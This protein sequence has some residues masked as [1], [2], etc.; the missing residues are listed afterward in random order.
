[1][2]SAYSGQRQGKG[3]AD[4]TS[5]YDPR[6]FAHLSEIEQRHFW[7]RSRNRFIEVLANQVA[8]D[9]PAGFRI[10]EV[11]CGVGSVL[12]V[13]QR[14]CGSGVVF[15]VDLYAEALT[16]ARR[17]DRRLAQADATALPF[18][19]AFAL[20]GLFDVLEHVS[21]DDAVLREVYRL[22]EPPGRL[23]L[24]APAHPA[25]WSH[26][27][28]AACHCRRY[29]KKELE[30]KLSRAGFRIEY[31]T[32]CLSL[33]VPFVWLRRTIGKLIT[34]TPLGRTLTPHRLAESELRIV[35]VVNG[36]LTWLLTLE[37]GLITRRIA[38]PVGA[39][40]LALASR[41]R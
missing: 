6:F 18:P 14:A 39:S 27:D 8:R 33:L 31:M 5:S 17:T 29:S 7:F 36:L 1:M 16:Y 2:S 38:L 10:L 35:P 13:L 26:F 34:A 20:V 15:G 28:E 24:T 25:L 21:D 3:A 41:D 12:G 23:L 37:S 11:G 4:A 32:Y 9:L 19:A 22:L 40:L 30:Q